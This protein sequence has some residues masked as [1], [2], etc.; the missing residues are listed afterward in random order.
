VNKIDDIATKVVLMYFQQWGQGVQQSVDALNAAIKAAGID[1][2]FV[3]FDDEGGEIVA[4]F[5]GR[6][7]QRAIQFRKD[8]DACF[9]KGKFEREVASVVNV[10]LNYQ[11]LENKIT[12]R[13]GEWQTAT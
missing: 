11:G 4:G 2:E 1:A 10:I 13:K 7:S 5:K 9:P 3:Q 8:L 12:R 6:E